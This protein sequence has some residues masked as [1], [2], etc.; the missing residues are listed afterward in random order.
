M[1]KHL[2]STKTMATIDQY[3]CLNSVLDSVVNQ[4]STDGFRMFFC[5]QYTTASDSG[6]EESNPSN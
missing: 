4:R 1:F 5:I 6:E 3:F 2:V